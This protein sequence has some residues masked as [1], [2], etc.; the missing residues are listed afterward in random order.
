[1]E[2]KPC[3]FCGG[4]LERCDDSP[5]YGQSAMHPEADC[6]F[7]NNLLF[8]KDIVSMWNK[9]NG[10]DA[11][12]AEIA[13]LTENNAKLEK[14]VEKAAHYINDI[15][16]SCPLDSHNVCMKDDVTCDGF[17]Y[18]EWQVCWREWLMQ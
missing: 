1:M 14:A 15:T 17:V 12:R 2:L 13:K 7:S 5:I 3:P 6:L 10:I 18:G 8:H 11:L 9:R 4:I 16:G